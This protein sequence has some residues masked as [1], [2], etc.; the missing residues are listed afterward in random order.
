MRASSF[1]FD[2][3]GF[4]RMASRFQRTRRALYLVGALVI[5]AFIGWGEAIILSY[6][7]SHDG[8][9]LTLIQF[10][11]G[12]L[13]GFSAV[14]VLLLAYRQLGIP[15]SS[16]EIRDDGVVL[17]AGSAR[18]SFVP[19]RQGKQRLSIQARTGDPRLPL[20][21]QYRLVAW[22]VP[23][24]LRRLG[25]AYSQVIPY[26]YV[27]REAAERVLETAAAHAIPIS[28]QRNVN[29]RENRKPVTVYR[30]DALSNTPVQVP[31]RIGD[32]LSSA[33]G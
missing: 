33:Q 14:S 12:L 28:V 7:P 21:L 6:G 30:I 31:Y 29:L 9:F 32:G 10:I 27:P 17:Y 16:L 24:G 1:A 3:T 18:Q 20:E 26:M 15:S 13:I 5:L 4:S 22:P 11:A 19:W 2:L 25:V 8:F 23:E